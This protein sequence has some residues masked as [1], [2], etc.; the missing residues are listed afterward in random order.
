MKPIKLIMNAFGP[1]GG[2]ETVEFD[3]LYDNG[4]FLITGPTGAGKTT[5]FDGI[6]YALFGDVNMGDRDKLG[7][8]RSQF[9]KETALTSVE[10]EFELKGKVYKIIRSPKQMTPKKRGVGLKEEGPRVELHMPDGAVFTKGDEIN[11]KGEH[12]GKI[13]EILG[14]DID[15]FKKIIMIPQGDFRQFLHSN[16][17]DKKEI[18]RKIFGTEIYEKMAEKIKSECDELE[19][20]IK[21]A[22]SELEKIKS[23]IDISE[24]E[25]WE[26]IKVTSDYKKIFDYLE[27]HIVGL[28]TQ[29]SEME[30]EIDVLGKKRDSLV[31]EKSVAEGINK[32]FD[33][34]A[35]SKV[36]RDKLLEGAEEIE[37]LRKRNDRYKKAVKLTERYTVLTGL[38]SE[39]KSNKEKIEGL[40]GSLKKIHE[41]NTEDLGNY[42]SI[43]KLAKS[44]EIELEKLKDYETNVKDYKDNILKAKEAEIDVKNTKELQDNN[45]GNILKQKEILQICI[46]QLEEINSK[47]EERKELTLEKTKLSGR[48][49]ILKGIEE[50]H[51]ELLKEIKKIEDKKGDLSQTDKKNLKAKQEYEVADVLLNNSL[52]VK[53][54]AKLIEGEPCPVC[55]SLNHPNPVK[56][57]DGDVTPE[58]V[59]SKMNRYYDL[60]NESVKIKT[61]LRGMLDKR[62]ELEEK[63]KKKC[64]ENDI[65]NWQ[66][67]LKETTVKIGNID[68]ILKTLPV[69]NDIEEL[70]NEKKKCDEKIKTL[71][72]IGKEL[73]KKVGIAE[74]ER[75]LL[76][77]GISTIKKDLDSK[78]ISVETYEED[79]KNAKEE[80]K[81]SKDHL[82]KIEKVIENIKI[83]KNELELKECELIKNEEK[84]IDLETEFKK[85]LEGNTFIEEE[86]YLEA[87]K[88][89]GETLEEKIDEYDTALRDTKREI[90][91]LEKEIEGKTKTDLESYDEKI[92]DLKEKIIKVDIDRTEL[93]SRIKNIKNSIKMM[94]SEKK[95]AG[96]TM[97]KYTV[98]KKLS[99]LANGKTDTMINFETYVL[100]SYFSRVLEEANTR[101]KTMSGGRYSLH[102]REHAKNKVSAG[103]LDIIIYDTHTGG[104]RDVKTLSGGETFKASLSLALGLSDVVQRES[105]GIQLDSIFI[106]EG[107]GT[108]DDE[109]LDKAMD[110]LIE[111]QSSG[112]LVGIIS[113]VNSLKERI[114]SQINIVKGSS[115]SKIKVNI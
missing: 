33:I 68:E 48:E 7:G 61:E 52:A 76:S 27:K 82:N 24:D 102:L 32:N 51:C 46:D 105:G 1:Y 18:L 25:I 13:R 113:H 56:A 38:R 42:A 54:G 92:K 89:D 58:E 86:D 80:S 20:S 111:L 96:T 108:L 3:K 107:F 63:I 23:G 84:I 2:A 11:G 59:S 5:I 55:G 101:L 115:G 21:N 112:R 40:K 87:K 6:T 104:K 36:T 35:E 43:N 50:L 47:L 103:G 64:V 72:L 16:S 74:K 81:K 19:K 114:F 100:A 57:M 9:A 10:L 109:S 67:D 77:G 66:E 60:M 22:E 62:I 4:L 45:I 79:L 15:Q 39:I 30:E 8:I 37:L 41:D 73:T 28:Q 70:E 31:S 49:N 44:K 85:I 75:D 110:T 53:I 34:L 95:K 26:E 83:K 90:K 98:I 69:Q 97:G 88:E 71:E 29:V 14:I 78:G 106:D 93:S 65:E 94:D 99:L 12:I 17:N 91:R